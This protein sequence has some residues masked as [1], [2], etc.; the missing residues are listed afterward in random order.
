MLVYRPGKAEFGGGT[1]E[2]NK[3]LIHHRITHTGQE[4][5]IWKLLE[6]GVTM[7]KKLRTAF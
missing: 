3:Q 2:A 6:E 1:E 7:E 5:V 4:L